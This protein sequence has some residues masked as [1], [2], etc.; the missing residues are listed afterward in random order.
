MTTLAVSKIRLDCDGN[1]AKVYWAVVDLA[2]NEQVSPDVLAPVR[3]VVDAI[4]A[5]DVVLAI[6]HPDVPAH[7]QGRR[8]EVVQRGSGAKSVG[9]KGPVVP[10][11]ELC[12][13]PKLDR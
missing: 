6:F 1:V 11:Q 3:E 10:T 13:M 2:S 9:L 7:L 5:G 4:Q 12:D 8:F